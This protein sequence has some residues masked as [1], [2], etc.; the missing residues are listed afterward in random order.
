MAW[1]T[2]DL[3]DSFALQVNARALE[4]LV[5][6]DSSFKLESEKPQ[7]FKALTMINEKVVTN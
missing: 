2:T 6:L 1:I 7:I 3:K 4:T 5:F